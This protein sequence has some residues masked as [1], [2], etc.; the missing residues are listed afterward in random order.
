MDVENIEPSTTTDH[1]N[2][3]VANIEEISHTH[4]TDEPQA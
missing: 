2:N 3:W 4:S 1:Y